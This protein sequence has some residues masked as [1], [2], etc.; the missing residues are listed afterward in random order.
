M[1]KNGRYKPVVLKTKLLSLDPSVTWTKPFKSYSPAISEVKE[2]PERPLNHSPLNLARNQNPISISLSEH[3][4]PAAQLSLSD[5]FRPS[6][7][8]P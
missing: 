7:V 2:V 8:G 5:S 1:C 4:F 6:Q 3:S